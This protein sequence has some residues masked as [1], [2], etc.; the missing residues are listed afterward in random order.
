[1]EQLGGETRQP[2]LGRTS[3][4]QS[5]VPTYQF[6]RRVAVPHQPG[7]APPVVR[8]DLPEAQLLLPAA[9][10]HGQ[11][12]APR[13]QGLLLS[14]YSTDIYMWVITS[15]CV[16]CLHILTET[17]LRSRFRQNKLES[18]VLS[19]NAPDV[20]KLCGED[21]Q[22]RN[23]FTTTRVVFPML[24]R[25]SRAFDPLPLPLSIICAPRTQPST[26]QPTSSRPIP[27]ALAEKPPKSSSRSY[28][29]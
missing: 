11:L 3:R 24:S 13:K 27:W 20:S 4:Q 14:G 2:A 21:K 22:P 7:D 23:E 8:P 17:V 12:G 26:P 5:E 9:L 16:Q 18:P 29:H 15:E 1:M 19:C 6:P 10:R 28:Y 25:S